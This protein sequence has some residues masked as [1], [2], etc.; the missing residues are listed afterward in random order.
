MHKH[1]PPHQYASQHHAAPHQH[2]P[3]GMLTSGRQGRHAAPGEQAR[4]GGEGEL[5][6][7]RQ[8]G[9]RA[10]AGGESDAPEGREVLYSGSDTASERTRAEHEAGFAPAL[11]PL[12]PSTH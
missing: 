9:E 11:L 1:S 7:G 3:E 8:R 5:Y 12:S 10:P 4:P 6:S 2:G